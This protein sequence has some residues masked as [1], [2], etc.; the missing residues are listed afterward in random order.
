MRLVTR[1]RE[2]I[3]RAAESASFIGDNQ[4]EQN[5]IRSDAT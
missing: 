3:A 5:E 4:R 2:E 1:A